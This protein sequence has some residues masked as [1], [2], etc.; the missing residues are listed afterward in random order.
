M[1]KF[2]CLVLMATAVM[3]ASCD[4][5]KAPKQ[6]EIVVENTISADREYMFATYGEYKWYETSVTLK[7]FLD[8]ENDG[9]VETVSSL[10]QV[11][12]KVDSCYDTKVV[13]STYSLEGH[14]VVVKDGFVF[15]DED[16]NKEKLPIT[17]KQAFD[18]LMASN[19]VKPHSRQCVLRKE[20]GPKPAA[21]QYIFGND[22][23]RL[24]VDATNGSVSETSPAFPE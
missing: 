23:G 10:F 24:Y 11:V 8:E 3:L 21:P 16:L 20:V 9:S 18:S 14:D 2:I 19:F 7:N 15:S 22:K 6:V 1:R 12:T 17:F 4:K 5:K 13:F